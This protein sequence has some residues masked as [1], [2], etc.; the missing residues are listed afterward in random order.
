[1]RSCLPS[2][3]ILISSHATAFAIDLVHLLHKAVLVKVAGGDEVV[4]ARN[5]AAQAS[6]EALGLVRVGTVSRVSLGVVDAASVG[7]LGL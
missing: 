7:E 4:L 2:F 3:K 6:E 5:R 1:M